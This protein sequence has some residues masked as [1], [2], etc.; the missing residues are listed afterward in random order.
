MDFR[1][2]LLAV[3][4]TVASSI[5]LYLLLRK[6]DD[7]EDEY[8]RTITAR[9]TVI[10]MRI[11]RAAVGHVIGRDG[12]N[13]R[14]VQQD[15]NTKIRFKDP[16]GNSEDRVCIIRGKAEFAQEAERL[17]NKTISDRPV[18][19]TIT[20]SV[21]Q[22]ACGRIIG[23][24]GESIRELCAVS[25]AKVLIDRHNKPSPDGMRVVT[26][27]G[28]DEQIRLAKDLISEKVRDEQAMRRKIE[29]TASARPNRLKRN[30]QVE[31]SVIENGYGC[32]ER[33][34]VVSTCETLVSTSSDGYVE[35]FVSAVDNPSHFWLQVKS[36]RSVQ[37]DQLVERMTDFY[38]N[39]DRLRDHSL[40]QVSIGGLVAARFPHDDLW[41]RARITDLTTAGARDENTPTNTLDST[42][43]SSRDSTHPSI[44]PIATSEQIATLF[45]VDFGDSAQM[46]LSSLA[47]L[48]GEFSSLS[49]QAIECHLDGVKPAGQ[50]WSEAAT[51]CF[52]RLTYA[53]QWKTLMARVVRYQPVSATRCVP[54]VTL[55]DTNTPQ[56]IAIGKELVKRGFA[57]W[58]GSDPSASASTIV[59]ERSPV[60]STLCPEGGD[61][62]PSQ[63]LPSHQE[64]TNSS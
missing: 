41:Y 12:A 36:P 34:D 56:D 10:E 22:Q 29:M 27:T 40:D 44:Q 39:G 51:E 54:V 19:T 8:L 17:I 28:T 32:G 33:S 64:T 7:E 30:F 53:S 1:V 37:L 13:I 5:A 3:S 50:M 26:I 24:G 18:V 59:R 15:T 35:V 63:P 4:L 47:R 6:N 62:T 14:Q 58:Q 11:P 43:D 52:E 23:R 42:N 57:V 20:L 21:P 25:H 61:A 9:Q 48:R 2:T 16:V 45:Y 49:H 55:I 46:K 60:P 38:S 31:G